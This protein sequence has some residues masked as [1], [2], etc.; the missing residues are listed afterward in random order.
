MGDADASSSVTGGASA[1]LIDDDEE[2]IVQCSG[3]DRNIRSR[4]ALYL[5]HLLLV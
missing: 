3:F 4:R 5:P 1:G 2:D